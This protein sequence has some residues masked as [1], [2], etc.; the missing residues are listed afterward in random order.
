MNYNVT[1]SQQITASTQM[2]TCNGTNKMREIIH[3]EIHMPT[4]ASKMRSNLEEIRST[5]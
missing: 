4:P 2:V 5:K 3:L 1:I